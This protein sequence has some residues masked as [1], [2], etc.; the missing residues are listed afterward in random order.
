MAQVVI[1]RTPG[2]K[3]MP[4]DIL[5]PKQCLCVSDFFFDAFWCLYIRAKEIYPVSFFSFEN[6]THHEI[7]LVVVSEGGGAS[8]GRGGA[9]S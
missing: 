8:R 9:Y 6:T 5:I 4:R 2:R 1:Y 3:S 7:F